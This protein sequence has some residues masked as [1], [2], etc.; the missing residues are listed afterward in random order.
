MSA[1]DHLNVAQTGRPVQLP[2]F[3]KAEHVLGSLTGTV[4]SSFDDPED[5]MARKLVESKRSKGH[6]SGVHESVSKEGVLNAVQLVHGTHGALMMGHGHHRVAAA[7]EISRREGRDMWIP[8]THTDASEKTA[9][10]VSQG[11]EGSTEHKMRAL[12]DYLNWSRTTQ[13]RQADIA[14]TVTHPTE[15][16]KQKRKRR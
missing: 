12:S 4:D 11:I 15:K 8:V 7:A 2:M 1:A 9:Y 5:V 14:W 10:P 3:M 16:P 6:G 13:G